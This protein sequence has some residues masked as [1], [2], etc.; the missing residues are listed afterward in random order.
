MTIKQLIK[1]FKKSKNKDLEADKFWS[2]F[3]K[4]GGDIEIP[5]NKKPTI[6]K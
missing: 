1:K 4:W 2:E 6:I 3:S 5:Q